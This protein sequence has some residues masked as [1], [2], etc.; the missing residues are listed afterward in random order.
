MEPI[1]IGIDVAKQ[2]LDVH[3]QPSGE[4]F[5]V[6]RDEAGL[7]DL[8]RRLEALR[9]MLIA[10]E[11]TGGSEAVVAATLAAAALPV[12]V[13]NPRQIREFAR[14]TGR[15]AKTDALDARAIAAFG[16]AVRP[17]CGRSQTRRL[18]YWGS[19]WRG[20][21]NWSTCSAPSTTAGG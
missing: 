10:L 5:T 19:S 2:R 1:F 13:V 16:A 8:V 20:D 18:G 6:T 21:A 11:A 14:A 12:V 9:P 7:A 3:V 17:A 4:A 15:L